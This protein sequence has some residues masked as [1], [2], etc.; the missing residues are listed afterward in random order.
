VPQSST[1]LQ[2][3]HTLESMRF[4][5]CCELDCAIGAASDEN[6]FIVLCFST[7]EITHTHSSVHS[8]LRVYQTLIGT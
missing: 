7:N 5:L 8:P 2:N 1:T 3:R 6:Q 4:S